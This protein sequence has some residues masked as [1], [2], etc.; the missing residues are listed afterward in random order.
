MSTHPLHPAW[1]PLSGQLLTSSGPDEVYATP[2]TAALYRPDGRA[3]GAVHSRP[4]DVLL[5]RLRHHCRRGWLHFLTPGQSAALIVAFGLIVQ[6]VA[7]WKLRRAVKLGRLVPFLIGGAIGVPIGAELLRWTSPAALRVAI[8]IIL[9]VFSVY[10]LWRPKL[11]SAT[12]AGPVADGG[13]GIL[14]GVI[15][16]ATG[17]AGI[18]ATVWCSL[19]GWPAAEQQPCSNPSAS[20]RL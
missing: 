10:S 7:V 15:G 17:L 3:R 18:A 12:G 13:V 1:L 5:S 9:V 4:L 8:G 20:R 19:H 16:G 2:H 11:G 14:N 6:G